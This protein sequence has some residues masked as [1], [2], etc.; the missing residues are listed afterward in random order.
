[1]CAPTEINK[2]ANLPL[3]TGGVFRPWIASLSAAEL[4][5]FVIRSSPF[6]PR[7]SG[8]V[9]RHS[10]VSVSALLSSRR[11]RAQS[12]P[13]R[14]ISGH[15]PDHNLGFRDTIG[16]QIG[17]RSGHRFN[18]QLQSIQALVFIEVP[19][20]FHA[21]KHAAAPRRSEFAGAPRYLH[22]PHSGL[23]TEDS[24]HRPASSS[25]LGTK[26]SCIPATG[27]YHRPA[28]DVLE[29]PA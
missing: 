22:L 4:R 10:P 25:E 7:V 28:R 16:T 18:R 11:C 6:F 14:P 29:Y 2:F 8:F 13:D 12:G 9:I 26:K 24:G 21:P 3:L 27:A 17:H 19:Q 15:T 20:T 5:A 1:M 23:G